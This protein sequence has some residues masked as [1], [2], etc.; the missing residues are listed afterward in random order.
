[1]KYELYQEIEVTDEFDVF[2]FISTG[3]N[4]DVL[5]R[6]AFT[7]TEQDKVYNLSL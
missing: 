6:V 7:K 1:M 5:K 3:G 2:H 4:G